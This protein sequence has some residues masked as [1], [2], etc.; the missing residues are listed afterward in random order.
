M[1]RKILI[2][3]FAL[4][5]L[6]IFVSQTDFGI[7]INNYLAALFF[8]E[9]IS[10]EELSAKYKRNEKIKI[11]IVPGHDNESWGTDFNGI[12]EADFNLAVGERLLDYFRADANFEVFITRDQNGYTRDFQGYFQEQSS[13]IS[14]FRQYWQTVFK[15]A[16]RQGQVTSKILDYHGTASG[17]DSLKLYGIN[18]WAND[19]RIDIVLHLHFN[20]YPTRPAGQAGIY[21]GF[22]MYVPEEQLPN[23]RASV[24]IAQS[25]FHQ[26][27]KYF[28]QSD[29]PI[30]KKG[31]IEDQEL[32]AIGSNASL[33]AA[34]VLIEYGYIYEPPFLHPAIRD[35]LFRELAFQT[36]LSIKKFFEAASMTGIE[37][38]LL[39]Y[40]WRGTFGQ[41]ERGENVLALQALLA[42]EGLYGCPLTGYFGPCTRQA[43]LDF[44]EKYGL[45]KNGFVDVPT[46]AKLQGI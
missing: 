2:T 8:P 46:L 15:T 7:K 27:D 12:K 30:E 16:V 13:L 33:N 37:T 5:L 44:Q 1:N 35:P 38:T 14:E 41:G 36:Y 21:F 23:S 17:E 42:R 18:K 43:V 11:L 28:D 20:D 32:I 19:N 29:L 24:K 3:V 26:L 39:P 6:I 10:P 9:R 34:S 25:V 4:G 31:I 40:R 22:S 45:V